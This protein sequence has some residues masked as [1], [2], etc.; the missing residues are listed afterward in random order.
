MSSFLLLLNLIKCCLSAPPNSIQF[1][2]LIS[3]ASVTNKET[4][5]GVNHAEILLCIKYRA[6]M[7]CSSYLEIIY[8]L[9]S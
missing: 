1:K 2:H 7:C 8:I 6:I 4:D 9:A 5:K 3:G